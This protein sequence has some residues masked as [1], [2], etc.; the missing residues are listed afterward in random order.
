MFCQRIIFYKWQGFVRE[1]ELFVAALFFGVLGIVSLINGDHFCL[2][3]N[4]IFR[5]K[6]RVPVRMFDNQRLIKTE[7]K[8]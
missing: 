1:S 6:S 8:F 2:F 7:N 4:T 3:Q 5:I